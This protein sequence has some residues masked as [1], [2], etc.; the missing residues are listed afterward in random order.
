LNFFLKQSGRVIGILIR[1]QVE[2]NKQ[3]EM[4]QMCNGWL[5]L[6]NLPPA[7]LER[8]VYQAARSQKDLL[9]IEQWS[10]EVAMNAYLSSDRFRALVGA[11]KLTLRKRTIGRW[12]CEWR[13]RMGYAIRGAGN[14]GSRI[15]DHA[16]IFS[17]FEFR[18]RFRI[19]PRRT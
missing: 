3:H 5:A 18:T 16:R 13:G 4:I 15:S 14:L 12:R 17:D 19:K 10:G 2:P 1:A 8:H 7:C 11:V 9:L 6:S